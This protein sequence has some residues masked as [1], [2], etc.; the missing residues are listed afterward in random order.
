MIHT[1]I[2]KVQVGN[3]FGHPL[4][5]LLLPAPIVQ[6]LFCFF[7][8]PPMRSRRF[9]FFVVVVDLGEDFGSHGTIVLGH[10]NSIDIVLEER[11]IHEASGKEQQR[12]AEILLQTLAGAI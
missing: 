9:R 7:S 4:P 11:T 6:F 12:D 2:L 8:S 1:Y 3:S 10:H 5:L